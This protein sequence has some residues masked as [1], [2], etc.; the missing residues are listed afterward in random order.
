MQL[1]VFIIPIL[2]QYQI[3]YKTHHIPMYLCPLKVEWGLASVLNLEPGVPNQ[4]RIKTYQIHLNFFLITFWSNKKKPMLHST[5]VAIKIA[6]NNVCKL[7][8]F[9]LLLQINY[10][11]VKEWHHPC[12]WEG[13]GN[14]WHVCQYSLEW[15]HAHIHSYNYNLFRMDHLNARD[16]HLIVIGG[17]LFSS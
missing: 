15:S 4:A 1:T 16:P 3:I 14:S 10:L 5:Y 2:N 13:E 6:W 12:H 11:L 7:S 17:N 8:C 9:G